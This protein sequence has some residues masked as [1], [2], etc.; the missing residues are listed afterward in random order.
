V[1]EK[2]LFRPYSSSDIAYWEDCIAPFF[3]LSYQSTP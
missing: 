3:V 2:T 1:R